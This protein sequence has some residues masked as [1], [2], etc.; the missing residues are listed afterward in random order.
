MKFFFFFSFFFFLFLEKF[1]GVRRIIL[2]VRVSSREY[3]PN[4]PNKTTKTLYATAIA[5]IA[6]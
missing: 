4:S 3:S 6:P 2:Y 1:A 5:R